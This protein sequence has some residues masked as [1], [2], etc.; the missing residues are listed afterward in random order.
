MELTVRKLSIELSQSTM[1]PLYPER[2]NVPL[3][4][5]AHNCPFAPLKLP[6]TDKPITETV[7][8]PEVAVGHAPF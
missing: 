4:A 8:T 1:F 5:F 6:P 2:V 7:K 3:L